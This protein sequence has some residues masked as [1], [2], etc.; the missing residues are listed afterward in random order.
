MKPY[1]VLRHRLH[2]LLQHFLARRHA[3]NQRADLA[4]LPA[5]QA[6]QEMP[7]HPA[8]RCIQWLIMAFALSAL[9]WSMLARLDVVAIAEGRIVSSD[10]SKLI[11]SH[12]VAVVKAIHAHDGQTVRAGDVLIELDASQTTADKDRLS[13]DRDDAQ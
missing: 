10:Q 12:E 7:I 2:V 1:T 6:L 3:R 5:V 4:F 11:Q 9:A 13:N 8:P